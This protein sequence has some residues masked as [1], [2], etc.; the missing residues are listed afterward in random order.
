MGTLRW[1]LLKY[2]HSYNSTGAPGYSELCYVSI[3]LSCEWIQITQARGYTFIEFS[4]Q[5]SKFIRNS[6]EWELCMGQMMIL[7]SYDRLTIV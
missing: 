1:F 5:V 7:T 6:E 2:T 3:I 4:F